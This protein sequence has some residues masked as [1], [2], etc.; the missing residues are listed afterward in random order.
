MPEIVESELKKQIE[1]AN[2]ANLYVLHGEEK[3]L[4]CHY[5][6]KLISKAA[7]GAFPDFNLQK[8]DGR[9]AAIEQIATAVEALPFMAEQKCVAVSDLDVASLGAVQ[10][11]QLKELIASIPETTVLILY[12]PSVVIDY[13]KDKK[14]KSFLM[15]AGKIGV[16][17]QLKK[18]S[19]ADLEKLLCS[20]A[21]KRGCELSRQNAALIVSSSGTDLQT[22]LNELE[23]LCAYVKEGEITADIIDRL[24]TKNLETTVFLLSKA[25]LSGDYDKAYHVLDLLFHQNEEPVAVLAVLSSA[26]IDLYRVR[27]ALQSGQSAK[28]PAEHF[29]YRG[30]EFLLSNAERDVKKFSTQM[31]RESLDAL[32][33]ADTALKSARGDRRLVMEKLIAELLLIA[34][35]GRLSA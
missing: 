22:L 6:D 13:K 8:F 24:V 31:L 2:L 16:T 17:A 35:K 30:R 4:I 1:K 9:T 25:I 10:S 28:T 3:Y 21:A 29:E 14:W 34:E 32:L 15:S 20:G 5:T 26:Y 11:D 23:K 18:R 27:T 19:N 12:Y 7:I 33:A